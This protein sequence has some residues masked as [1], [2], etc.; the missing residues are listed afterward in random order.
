MKLARSFGL[1]P[2][3]PPIKYDK[4][5][6]RIIKTI[7][8]TRDLTRELRKLPKEEALRILQ[9][10]NN[11]GDFKGPEDIWIDNRQESAD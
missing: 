3:Y 1:L 2:L 10:F 6:E 11:V 5:A 7:Q 9:A 4:S 8:L